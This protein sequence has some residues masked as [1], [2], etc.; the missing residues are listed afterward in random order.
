MT[1]RSSVCAG[2]RAAT[3]RALDREQEA[4][5]HGGAAHLGRMAL[6]RWGRG[7]SRQLPQEPKPDLLSPR[8]NAE[9]SDV[10]E[11][12]ERVAR[13]SGVDETDAAVAVR[14]R[15]AA[16]SPGEFDN[17]LSRLGHDYVDLVGATR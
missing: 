8:K 7:P 10:N 14:T 9:R 4:L 15:C 17:V 5:V 12:V 1:G 3:G 11:F 6:R 2:F 16:I 13:R